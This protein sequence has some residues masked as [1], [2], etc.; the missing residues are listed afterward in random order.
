MFKFIK[1]VFTGPSSSVETPSSSSSTIENSISGYTIPVYENGK[2][3]YELVLDR[4][5]VRAYDTSKVIFY[6][7]FD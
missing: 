2:N 3:A 1:N 4:H 7:I 6:F 5:S